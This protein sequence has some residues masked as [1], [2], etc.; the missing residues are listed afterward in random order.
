MGDFMQ[1]QPVGL[2]VTLH[3]D[4]EISQTD[5]VVEYED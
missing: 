1:D 3:A 4:G 5:Y 2:H